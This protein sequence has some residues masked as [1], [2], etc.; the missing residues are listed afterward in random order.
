M[1]A[2]ISPTE[3]DPAKIVAAIRRLRNDAAEPGNNSDLNQA[4]ID[5]EVRLANVEDA[6]IDSGNPYL[7]VG[8]GWIDPYDDSTGIDAGDSSNYVRTG[9][10]VAPSTTGGAEIAGAT[11]FSNS[12]TEAAEMRDNTTNLPAASLTRKSVSA[13]APQYVG[14]QFSAASAIGKFKVY[15]S[16]DQGF[17]SGE[18][19]AVTMSWRAVAGI[20]NPTASNF[21]TFGTL[22]VPAQTFTD[23]SNESAGREFLNTKDRTSLFT[24]C[25]LVLQHAGAGTKTFVISEIEA[26]APD[27]P[28]SMTLTSIALVSPT[29]ISK[30]RMTAF[31]EL[32]EPI[33]L[34]TDLTCEVSANNGS[35][36][37]QLTLADESV[38]PLPGGS[39]TSMWRRLSAPFTTVTGGTVPRFRWK[40]FNSKMPRI[41]SSRVNWK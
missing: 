15:G 9:G 28:Q 33:T 22:L 11:C 24:R 1:T 31:I 17:V 14:Y 10:Y 35:N 27:I 34:N 12:W 39:T 32:I 20:A 3:R 29:A 38:A 40:T 37:T 36:W 13:N 41:H 25:W 7:D 6:L 19:P 2:I 23:T 8:N 30:M 18:N 4:L 26:Y 5:L 16:N 21:Q